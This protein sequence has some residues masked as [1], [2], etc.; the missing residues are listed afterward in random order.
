MADRYALA[1]DIYG[2]AAAAALDAASERDAAQK[3]LEVNY[4]V[5]NDRALDVAKKKRDDAALASR[6]AQQT[7]EE[8]CKKYRGALAEVK[9][10]APRR[11]QSAVA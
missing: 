2:D 8:R 7:S 4:T 5:E 1:W 6:A 10:L 3:R 11:V 9:R